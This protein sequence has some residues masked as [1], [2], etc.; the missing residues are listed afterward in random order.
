MTGAC[1]FSFRLAFFPVSFVPEKT[2]CHFSLSRVCLSYPR[3]VCFFFTLNSSLIPLAPPA[4]PTYPALACLYTAFFLLP[5]NARWWRISGL[6]SSTSFC[7]LSELL[8]FPQSRHSLGQR[9]SSL[10]F[11][12]GRRAFFW[13]C[14]GGFSPP[15]QPIPS[16]QR[17][18]YGP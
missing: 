3:N 6:G 9:R 2:Q 5:Q 8:H 13:F 14:N 16:S 18:D 15:L 10:L 12:R 17:S 11:A 4:R 7:F 1:C